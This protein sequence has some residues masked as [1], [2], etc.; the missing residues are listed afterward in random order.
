MCLMSSC[1]Y[2]GGD[3]ENAVGST[4]ESGRGSEGRTPELSVATPEPSK[5][6]LQ[7]TPEPSVEPPQ[8]TSE[9]SIEPP[10]AS[11]GKEE[12]NTE[13]QLTEKSYKAIFIDNEDFRNGDTNEKD[14]RSVN[15]K[16]IKKTF[17][18]DENDNAATVPKFA[19]VDLDGDGMN[20]VVLW[21]Q[22]GG[23]DE[24]FEVLRYR[25]GEVY[26]YHFW[27][28]EFMGLKADGTFEGSGGAADTAI[29]NMKFTEDG[30][31]ID[32]LYQSHGIDAHIIQYY[33]NGELISEEE[34]DEAVKRQNEK[35]DVVWYERTEDNVNLAF[36]N[37]F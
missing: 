36:E 29:M 8:V 26:G 31:V 6:P 37:R 27:Y 23:Y 33:A 10:Q 5:E 4:S 17:T 24:G 35:P 25:E 21:V 22:Y 34:F 20:E 7:T 13:L 14:Y 2:S 28:R 18:A 12:D 3:E 16:T 32:T 9:A 11:C 19:I 30:Y 15:I 1:A